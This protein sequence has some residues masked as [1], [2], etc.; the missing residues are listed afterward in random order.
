ML[1]SIE[2]VF[3]MKLIWSTLLFLSAF[4]R[5]TFS[6]TKKLQDANS[7]DSTAIEFT[8]LITINRNSAKEQLSQ[9]FSSHSKFSVPRFGSSEISG[10]AAD[11][12]LILSSSSYVWSSINKSTSRFKRTKKIRI[13]FAWIGELAVIVFMVNKMRINIFKHTIVIEFIL[14]VFLKICLISSK[15]LVRYKIFV[16]FIKCINS[17]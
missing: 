4:T 10:T 14:F 17:S 15:I 8:T 13:Y 6:S 12:K 2:H 7:E 1:Q 16:V 9:G 11:F 5:Y 3:P